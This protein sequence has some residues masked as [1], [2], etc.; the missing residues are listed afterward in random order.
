[1]RTINRRIDINFFDSR[2]MLSSGDCGLNCYF[3]HLRP[4][5]HTLDILKLKAIILEDILWYF[6]WVNSILNDD[7]LL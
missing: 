4:V 6:D 3:T 7:L 2:T 5:F 1:M